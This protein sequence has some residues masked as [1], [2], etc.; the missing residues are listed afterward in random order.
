MKTENNTEQLKAGGR[1]APV[2]GSA[3][4]NSPRFY[5]KQCYETGHGQYHWAL[6]DTQTDARGEPHR[7]TCGHMVLLA[8]YPKGIDGRPVGEQEIPALITRLLTE[9]FERLS[10]KSNDQVQPR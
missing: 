6:C 10:A 4:S 1:C 9:H 2:P 7:V 3:D 8:D 5:W